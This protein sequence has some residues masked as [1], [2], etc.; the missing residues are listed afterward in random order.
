[1]SASD[2]SESDSSESFKSG[3]S[4]T[5]FMREIGPTVKVSMPGAIYFMTLY[6]IAPSRGNS[7]PSGTG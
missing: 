7:V 4:A 5:S 1:M 2:S 6:E 3:I